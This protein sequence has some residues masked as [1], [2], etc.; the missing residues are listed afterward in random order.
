MLAVLRP[1]L[2]NHTGG[3]RATTRPRYDEEM[4]ECDGQRQ[5]CRYRQPL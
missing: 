4:G 3:C 1:L 2:H 5:R